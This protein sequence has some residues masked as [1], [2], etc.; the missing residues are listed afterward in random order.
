MRLSPLSIRFLLRMSFVA[1]A[2]AGFAQSAPGG[3][4]PDPGY[5]LKLSADEVALTFRATDFE[6]N[7]LNDLTVNDLRF[8]R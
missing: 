2:C 5:V 8:A 4:Q 1:S 6:G 7:P 3:P